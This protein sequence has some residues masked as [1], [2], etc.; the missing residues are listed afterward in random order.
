MLTQYGIDSNHDQIY[1]RFLFKLGDRRKPAQSLYNCFEE[2]LEECGIRIEVEPDGTHVQ[3]IASASGENDECKTE[4]SATAALSPANATPRRTR[5][6]SF[7]SSPYANL[8]PA[9]PTG[10]VPGIWS[11]TALSQINGSGVSL[12][13][14]STRATTR[15]TEKTGE[16]PLNDR[17]HG[18][19][20]RKRRLTAQAMATKHTKANL[21][22]ATDQAQLSPLGEAPTS[23]MRLRPASLVEATHA[24][25]NSVQVDVDAR[26]TEPTPYTV[27][28]D[29]PLY[30]PSQTQL[31]RDV[32]TFQDF[33][34]RHTARAALQ[35]WCAVAIRAETVHK[36]MLEK[37]TR[38]D[39]ETLRRQG[40]QQWR[41]HLRQKR[42]KTQKKL[43]FAN[44]E[45]RAGKARDLYLLTKAF[46]HWAQ[47]SSDHVFR[48]LTIRRHLLALKY[49]N[50]WHDITLINDLKVNQ[51]KLSRY[52]Y[53]WKQACARNSTANSHAVILY[54]DSLIKT[55]YWRWFWAFCARRA[56]EWRVR[57][58]KK[59]VFSHWASEQVQVSHRQ[60]LVADLRRETNLK[61]VFSRWLQRARILGSRSCDA[62]GFN[63]QRQLAHTLAFWR[64]HRKHTL[65]KQ[66][67][68]NMADWRVAGTT[69]A[70]IVNRYRAIRQAETV[71]RLR[72]MRN[73]WTSW[74]DALRREYVVKLIND[75]VLIE[76]LYRWALAQRG[77][78]MRRSCERRLKQITLSEWTRAS[79]TRREAREAAA[80]SLQRSIH[81]SLMRS[82]I[83]HWKSRMSQAVQRDSLAF[84]FYAPRIV[85][86]II[87]MWSA[88][89]AVIHKFHHE[90]ERAA[91]YLPARRCLKGWRSAAAESKR[92]KRRNG[93]IEIRKR[94][95]M[96]LAAKVLHQWRKIVD[97]RLQSYK[98]ANS[99][100]RERL[101]TFAT[102][103]F[104]YWKARA[105]T[106]NAHNEEAGQHHLSVLA[107]QCLQQWSN[108]LRAQW[109]MEDLARLNSEMRITNLAF[110]WIHK[111]RLRAIEMRGRESNAQSLRN[112]YEKRHFQGIFRHWRDLSA[113]KRHLPQGQLFPPGSRREDRCADIKHTPD[114]TLGRTPETTTFHPASDL[115]DW[116]PSFEMNTGTM[117]TVGSLSTPSKRASRAKALVG[118]ST[119]PAGTP[120]Q[121]R[122]RSHIN[123]TPYSHRRAEL[124]RSTNLRGSNFG[125]ILEASPRTP[126]AE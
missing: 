62:D 40:F 48:T 110:S 44:L 14:P 86:E 15:P 66:Q 51:H 7:E 88:K 17:L 109:R 4:I 71:D 36:R 30:R 73:A 22:T 126:D 29:T 10:L 43:F 103:L 5:R 81:L 112:Y 107:G 49:F 34:I 91:V 79:I 45:R 27:N 57:K 60:K 105:V 39:L 90:A 100:D 58:L 111:I 55:A 3:E 124:G 74:N 54:E 89:G 38:H 52:I 115:E 69:F 84:E 56:P 102:G 24:T 68:S 11:S 122:L 98:Q 116:I 41:A 50:A 121:L 94:M 31:M 104:R 83:A 93:Y 95:K 23:Q 106:L 77:S 85:Q 42:K 37:A 76:Q 46:T 82:A 47:S 119:T 123:T 18:S 70:V 13:R 80:K 64:M 12:Q 65:P 78:L 97:E 63:R 21:E 33:K 114:N 99:W 6:V 120:F 26:D 108:L 59:K 96:K 16:Q 61:W 20:A 9:A 101:L 1:F 92:L 125:T 118:M 8:Q 87:V 28:P 75:R 113:E 53:L 35:K 32:H 67:I 72:I 25:R 2:L 117:P 19:Q